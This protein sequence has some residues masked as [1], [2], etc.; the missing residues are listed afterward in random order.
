MENKN[1]QEEK[2]FRTIKYFTKEELSNLKEENSSPEIM[3]LVKNSNEEQVFVCALSINSP[4]K[5]E[6]LKNII[7]EK[8]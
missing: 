6:I 2:P 3:D 7:Q 4:V 1:I 8:I 5:V